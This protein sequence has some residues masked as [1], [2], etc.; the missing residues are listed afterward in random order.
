[1]ILQRLV[2][3]LNGHNEQ[4]RAKLKQEADVSSV[5]SMWFQRLSTRIIFHYYPEPQTGGWIESGTHGTRT[6]NHPCGLQEPQVEAYLTVPCPFVWQSSDWVTGCIRKMIHVTR[7]LEFSSTL[8]CPIRQELKV[9]EIKWNR[10]QFSNCVLLHNPVT[11]K[12]STPQ[13]KWSLAWQKGQFLPPSF[14]VRYE[15]ELVFMP[16]ASP[17]FL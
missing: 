17:L 1:M 3:S 9:M 10:Q 12:L 5:S 8:Y 14:P 16:Y 15:T 7:V 13:L 6:I 2:H 4:S 11:V